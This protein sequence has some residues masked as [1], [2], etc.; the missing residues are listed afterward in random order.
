MFLE[1]PGYPNLNKLVFQDNLRTIKM[2]INGRN[3]C[4]CNSIHIVVRY[5][6]TKDII[7]KGEMMVKYY[8]TELMIADFFMKVLQGRAFRISEILKNLNNNNVS[9][10]IKERVKNYD[11]SKNRGK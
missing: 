8:P 10:P 4:T 2:E 7:E 1:H 5:L 6:F 3:S 11:I 9:F